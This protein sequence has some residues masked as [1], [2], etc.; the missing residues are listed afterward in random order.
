MASRVFAQ[1]AFGAGT[2]ALGL[3]VCA[4]K[5]RQPQPAQCLPPAAVEKGHLTIC[6][7]EGRKDVAKKG[8]QD[9]VP[10]CT[11]AQE[12]VFAWLGWSPEPGSPCWRSLHSNFPGALPGHAI[13][14]K[15]CEVLVAQGFTPDNTLFG[16]SICPDEINNQKGQLADSLKEFWGECFP[17]GGI[18]GPPFVGQTGWGAFCA[19]IPQDGN[20]VV[21]FGP[22]IGITDKGEIGKVHRHG[23]KGNSTACGAFVAAYNSCCNNEEICPEKHKHDMQQRFLKEQLYGRAKDIQNT[24]EPMAALAVHAFEVVKEKLEAVIGDKLPENGKLVLIGGVQLNM[25]EGM[26]DHFFPLMFEVR[27]KNAPN[28]DLLHVFG[29]E[30]TGKGSMTHC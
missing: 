22:H 15:S 17:L 24:P 16:Q 1:K 4:G 10:N 28:V 8:L 14:N 7:V 12:Q 5:L 29:C 19:H 18:G 6:N 3:A 11:S 30:T 20:I 25:P 26:Q 9:T 13:L 23:Q 2:S 21:L 27:S